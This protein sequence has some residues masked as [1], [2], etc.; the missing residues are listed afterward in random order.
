MLSGLCVIL[1]AVQPGICAASPGESVQESHQGNDKFEINGANPTESRQE[2]QR[3]MPN[4]LKL[5]PP[6]LH[7][8]HIAMGKPRYAH[9]QISQHTHSLKQDHGQIDPSITPTRMARMITEVAG[10]EKMHAR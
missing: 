9:A 10:S 1:L 8:S 6:H 7:P 2:S 5:H 3:T 4:H